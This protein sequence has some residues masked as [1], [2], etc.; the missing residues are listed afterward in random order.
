MCH[1]LGFRIGDG[2]KA[3]LHSQILMKFSEGVFVW[4]AT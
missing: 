2:V 3:T 4:L 1:L